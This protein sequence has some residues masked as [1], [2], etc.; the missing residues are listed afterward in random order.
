VWR[1]HYRRGGLDAGQHRYLHDLGGNAGDVR[2]GQHAAVE[3]LTDIEGDLPFPWLGLDSDNGGEFI[4]RHVLSWC[5]KGRKEPIYYTR[6][7]AYKSND[8]AHI[9]QKNWTHVRQWFG[10][11]RHDNPEVAAMINEV[12]GGELGQFLNL[13]TPSMKLKS[14]EQTK[15]GKEHRIY[16]KPLT[17]YVRVLASQQ[18]TPEK[19]AELKELKNRLNPFELE[20]GIQKKLKAIERVRRALE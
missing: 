11:E 12:A 15:E 13:F 16:D 4:N 17:P 7:R 6:S 14:K 3:Q 20:R 1:V 8:N 10:Y 18:V 19:K 5:Q 9:E 2:A